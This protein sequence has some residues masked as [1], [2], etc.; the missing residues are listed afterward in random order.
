MAI[1]RYA[2]TPLLNGRTTMATASVAVKIRKA[3]TSNKLAFTATVLKEGQRLDH[4]SAG[5]YGSPGYWWVIA[6]ASGIGW[7]LQCP[8]GTILWVPHNL[9]EAL[10]LLG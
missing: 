9:G 4:I 6:A 5:K 10:A 2:Y 8:P 7:G 3:C 1:S